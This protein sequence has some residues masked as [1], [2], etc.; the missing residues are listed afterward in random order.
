MILEMRTYLLK[1]GTT[2]E[3]SSAGWRGR[4]PSAPANLLNGKLP[5]FFLYQG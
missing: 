3:R 5:I 1:P 4:S 2:N